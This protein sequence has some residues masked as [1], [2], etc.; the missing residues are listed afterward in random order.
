MRLPFHA[1]SVALATVTLPG[2]A[3]AHDWYQGLVSPHG[4]VCCGNTDCRPVPY[5]IDA[6]TGKEEIEA[7]GNWW[8]VEYDKVLNLS[9]PDGGA[10]ACWSNPRGRPEFRCIILPGMASLAPAA[11]LAAIGH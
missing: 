3:G 5:R 8:P 2:T 7:N 6:S 10:H 4:V 1:L 9:T 11:T